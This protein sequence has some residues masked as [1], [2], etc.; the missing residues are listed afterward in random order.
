MCPG[1]VFRNA[2]IELL[3]S[4]CIIRSLP[5]S[6]A[7]FSFLR[8]RAEVRVLLL[9]RFCNYSN[10]LVFVG[11]VQ[12]RSHNVGD[13]ILLMFVVIGFCLGHALTDTNGIL[14]SASRNLV[15]H[16]LPFRTSSNL[17]SPPTRMGLPFA[18][19]NFTVLVD[20]VLSTPFFRLGQMLLAAPES[21]VISTIS[22]MASTAFTSSS[23]SLSIAVN[24]RNRLFPLAFFV[25]SAS[26]RYLHV[27]LFEE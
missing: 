24:A 10:K 1:A 25:S 3:E 9:Q 15:L 26:S 5:R 4:I 27:S 21:T 17:A 8:Y 2:R 22:S 11:M 16:F 23:S 6:P 20:I 7:L 18:A 12:S 13:T 14:T 19:T